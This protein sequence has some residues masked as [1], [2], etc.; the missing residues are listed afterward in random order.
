MNV[1]RVFRNLYRDDIR[2]LESTKEEDRTL[3]IILLYGEHLKEKSI[4]KERTI[5]QRINSVY[6][7][8]VI[9]LLLRVD[10]INVNESDMEI[11]MLMLKRLNYSQKEISKRMGYVVNFVAFNIAINDQYTILQNEVEEMLKK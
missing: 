6:E 1:Q 11:Y 7:F 8:D 10:W 4:I 9:R 2:V 5:K 3:G